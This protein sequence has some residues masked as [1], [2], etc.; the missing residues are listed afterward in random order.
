MRALMAAFFILFATPALANDDPIIIDPDFG[1]TPVIVERSLTVIP[2]HIP[3]MREM[4]DW[5]GDNSDY[6]TDGVPLPKIRTVTGEDLQ[7][8]YYGRLP[9]E[10]EVFLTVDALYF[11][12]GEIWIRGGIEGNAYFSTILHELVHHAQEYSD[13]E[14]ACVAA[15]EADAYA[16]GDKYAVEVLQDESLKSDPLVVMF[17]TQCARW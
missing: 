5:I 12:E 4:L 8:I 1:D 11:P 7:S 15:S 14:F 10:S 6:V 16:L 9:H 17:I 3:D 2:T 13:K